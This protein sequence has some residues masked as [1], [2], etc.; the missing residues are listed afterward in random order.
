MNTQELE[1]IF[2]LLIKHSST[3]SAIFDLKGNILRCNDAYEHLVGYTFKELINNA[4]TVYESESCMMREYRFMD[5]LLSGQRSDIKY[6]STRLT[7]DKR[8]IPVEVTAMLF[9]DEEGKPEFALKRI[10]DISG[11]LQSEQITMNQIFYLRTILDE[12]PLSFYFKDTKGRFLLNSMEHAQFLGA[13]NPNAMRG[14]TDFDFFAEVHAKKA[15]DDEQIV[16]RTGKSLNIVEKVTSKDGSIRWAQTI[17]SVFKDPNGEVM[18]TYGITRDITDLKLAEKALQEANDALQ[19]KNKQLE[20][21]IE[22]LTR[23]QNR[24]VFAEKMAALGSLIGGIAHEINTP[25]GAIKASS[26]NINEVVEKISVDLPWMFKHASQEETNWLFKLFVE[27]DARDISVFSR[28]ERQRKRELTSMFEENHI[29]NAAMT[30]DTIVSLKLSYPDDTYLNFLKQPNAQRLLQIL[31]ILFSLKRNS[32]NI[33]VSVEKAADVVRALRSYIYKNNTGDF[34]AAD[35]TETVNTVLILTANMI[36]HSK[37]VVTTELESIPPIFCRQDELC[38]V[39]TNLITNAIQAMGENG[40]LI[41]NM[42]YDASKGIILT[43]FKDNGPGIPESIRERI[44]EPF[45]TT[46]PKG[47]GTGMGLDICKQII[48]RHKGSIR[49][50]SETGKGTTFFVELPINQER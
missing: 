37:T 43:T 33:F 40:A 22:E 26:S 4:A 32:N 10:E 47:V 11:K 1:T 42:S 19:Q 25:L 34:E 14:K 8:V 48:E 13:T 20:D 30:A 27:A 9:T 46:K 15:F 36:K 18:G 7:K 21:T 23:T 3:C 29:E 35:L 31:K 39:W 38:Q 49:C 16:I 45:F 12:I 41:I 24:L 44:F 17:K 2:K 6:Q 5:D 28:E 50:E